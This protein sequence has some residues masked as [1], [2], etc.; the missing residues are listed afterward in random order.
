MTDPHFS[1]GESLKR[2]LIL[3]LATGAGVGYFPHAPGTAGTVLAIPFSLALNRVAAFSLPLALV[4]L[5]GF[6]TAAI[7]LCT[8]AAQTFGSKDPSV[9]V[10]DEIAGFLVANFLNPTQPA[11]FILAFIFFRLFDILKP[12]PASEL[13]KLPGGAGI[14]LDDVMAGIYTFIVLRALQ[15]LSYI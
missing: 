7:V 6:I 2:R 15:S 5:G 11:S 13:E 9:I 1:E 3:L 10:I 12:F 4:I 8:R 14:V